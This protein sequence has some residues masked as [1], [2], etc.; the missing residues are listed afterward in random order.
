MQAQ[1]VPSQVATMIRGAILI[2]VLASEFFT[3]F[4]LRRVKAHETSKS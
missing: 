1:G 3:E 2:F 4:K